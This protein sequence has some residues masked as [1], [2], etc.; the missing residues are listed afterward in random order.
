MLW[1][2]ETG[3]ELSKQTLAEGR[4]PEAENEVVISRILLELLGT[5]GDIGDTITLPYQLIKDGNYDY[6]KKKAVL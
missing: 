4:F 2:D 5:E 3:A 6:K 1:M